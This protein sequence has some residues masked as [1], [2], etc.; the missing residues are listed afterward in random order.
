M[1]NLVSILLW[2]VCCNPAIASIEV[3]SVSGKVELLKEADVWV[4][5]QIRDVLSSTDRLK[6]GTGGNII[7][8]E[9]DR[10]YEVSK[11]GMY[12]V[13]KVIRKLDKS[14]KSL[15]ASYLNFIW[16]ELKHHDADF[17]NHPEKYMKTMGTGI[18]SAY[19]FMFPPDGSVILGEEIFFLWDGNNEINQTFVLGDQDRNTLLSLVLSDSSLIMQSKSEL[20]SRPG[21]Y[22]WKGFSTNIEINPTSF[23]I[24]NDDSKNR[25]ANELYEFR[26]KL[27]EDKISDL[28][29]LGAFCEK[30]LLF[31]EAIEA[32][33][34]AVK[35][36]VQS[37]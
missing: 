11:E 37:N 19:G 7:L 10:I 34:Q 30:N 36:A 22:Y 16:Q 25:I 3:F 24:P 2:L 5:V 6:L 27:D 17:E 32:Y 14:S 9:K 28:L 31:V 26:N 35:L 33:Q 18:R 1:N 4:S 13:G 8:I 20:F 29:R 21:T 23:V 15:T 12:V